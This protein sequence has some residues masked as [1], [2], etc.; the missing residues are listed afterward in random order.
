MFKTYGLIYNY[1]FGSAAVSLVIK[2]MM[3]KYFQPEN[4][5]LSD[6]NYV[7]RNFK[8]SLIDFSSQG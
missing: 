4:S 1:G 7:C 5:G 2:K 3:H 8:Y 6:Q